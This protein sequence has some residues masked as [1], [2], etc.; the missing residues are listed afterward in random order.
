MK[1]YYGGFAVLV[2][3]FFVISAKKTF[4]LAKNEHLYYKTIHSAYPRKHFANRHGEY[5]VRERKNITAYDVLSA[6]IKKTGKAVELSNSYLLLAKVFM[7][8]DLPQKSIEPLKAALKLNPANSKAVL[9]LIK[10]YRYTADSRKSLDITEKYLKL[11]PREAALYYQKGLTLLK[12]SEYKSAYENFA[13][14]CRL[15]IDYCG[16]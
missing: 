6:E 7:N 13:A 5:L 9:E 15:N 1:Y 16:I 14:A 3:V 12:M 11:Y 4:K 8:E 2:L 10:S